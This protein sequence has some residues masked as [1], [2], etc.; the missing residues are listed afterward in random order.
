MSRV[1]SWSGTPCG[2]SLGFLLGGAAEREAQIRQAQAADS[3][4][5]LEDTL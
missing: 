5:P 4:K 3:E 1:A 2:S